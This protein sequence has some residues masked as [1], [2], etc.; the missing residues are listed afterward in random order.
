MAVAVEQRLLA[1]GA[2]GEREPASALADQKLLEQERVLRDRAGVV[3]VVLT[4][5]VGSPPTRPPEGSA[6]LPPVTNQETRMVSVL[7]TK[8]RLEGSKTK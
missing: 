5:R 2:E 8:V 7:V 6:T 1:L 3:Q 4:A